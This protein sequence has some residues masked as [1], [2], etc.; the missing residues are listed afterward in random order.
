MSGDES[1]GET[2]DGSLTLLAEALEPRV[3]EPGVRARLLEALHTSERWAPFAAEVARAFGLELAAAREALSR[4]HDPSA[5]VPGFWPGSRLLITP[6]LMRAQTV[7]SALPPGIRIPR[8]RHAGRE[9]TYVLDGVLLE[10]GAQRHT[11]GALLDMQG[12]SEHEIG[13]PDDGECL[14]VFSSRAG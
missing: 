8:H 5:W 13:V 3:V 1:G 12:G 7:V 10:N 11:T 2:D 4:I 14:V 9:L 6:Q